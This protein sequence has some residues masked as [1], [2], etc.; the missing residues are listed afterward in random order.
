M[1]RLNQEPASSEQHAGDSSKEEGLSPLD[2][3]IV[4]FIGQVFQVLEHAPRLSVLEVE[5][6]PPGAVVD[7]L[8][9]SVPSLGRI[10]LVQFLVAVSE[11]EDLVLV[12]RVLALAHHC[13]VENHF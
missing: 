9:V 2:G 8:E 5:H 3:V 11:S 7:W 6:S 10:V 1:L 4:V 12:R 13:I